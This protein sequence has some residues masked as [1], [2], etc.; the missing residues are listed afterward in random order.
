MDLA[1]PEDEGMARNVLSEYQKYET[2]QDFATAIDKPWSTAKRWIDKARNL[3]SGKVKRY[4]PKILT[5]DV[6]TSYMVMEYNTYDLKVY[7]SRHS[8]DHIKEDWFMLGAA[9]KFLGDK[10]VGCIS[11]C[12]KDPKND[13][14]VIQVLH[15]VL[16][17][18]DIII[19]HN[20]DAFDIKKF[21]ARAIKHGLPP[22]A[23]KKTIDTLKIAR[24]NFK[25]SS[26]TLRYI[27]NY[28]GLEAKDESPNWVKCV[29]GDDEEL[30]YMRKYN[31]QDVIVT[32][33]LYL[34]LRAY[35][36][37]HPNLNTFTGEDNCPT[38]GSDELLIKQDHRHTRTGKYEQFQCAGCG[39]WCDEG[40]NSFKAGLR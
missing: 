34:K 15:D 25:F 17:Q 27:C 10:S 6:E 30:R 38:C 40:K 23:P 39:A 13:Y 29:E 3:R 5:W 4:I 28:L 8:I 2:V 18:A 37:N 35:M 20:S 19:G 1:F 33:Q 7:L 11:V 12:P 24:Q 36:K 22:I 14:E 32:E 21:N 26:N 31:K 9:W 16:S